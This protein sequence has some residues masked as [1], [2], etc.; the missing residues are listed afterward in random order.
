MCAG[1]PVPILL[2]R[3]GCMRYY[4]KKLRLSCSDVL[5]HIGESV[6]NWLLSSAV[7]I[8]SHVL[9]SKL[10]LSVSCVAFTTDAVVAEHSE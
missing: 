9:W 8:S 7:G 5:G 3:L 4:L 1:E 2:M 6:T 10:K